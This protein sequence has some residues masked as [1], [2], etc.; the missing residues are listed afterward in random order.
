MHIESK[1]LLGPSDDDKKSPENTGK[2]LGIVGQGMVGYMGL[3]GTP[4]ESP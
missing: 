4:K 1:G 3:G 2:K